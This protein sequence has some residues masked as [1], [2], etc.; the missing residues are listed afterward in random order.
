MFRGTCALPSWKDTLRTKDG[1][2]IRFPPDH[3]PVGNL[4][5]MSI[6]SWST[7]SRSLDLTSPVPRL[8]LPL[9]WVPGCR[10]CSWRD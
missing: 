2:G 3:D 10:T 4:S 8:L 5:W 7:P 9:P 6:P 1:N